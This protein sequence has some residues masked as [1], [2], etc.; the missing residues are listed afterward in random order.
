M[1]TQALPAAS[2]RLLLPL[3]SPASPPPHPPTRTP[4]PP[5]PTPY[6]LAVTSVI[7]STKQ[8]VPYTTGTTTL[9][10]R[11]WRKSDQ[12]DILKCRKFAIC[13]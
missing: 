7:S 11:F 6:P 3:S 5:H 9:A 4:E 13:A 2:T 10:G 8:S 1:H 12:I